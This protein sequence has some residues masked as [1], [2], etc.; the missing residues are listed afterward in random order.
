[1]DGEGGASSLEDRS[2]VPFEPESVMPA[3]W[4]G[5]GG[6]GGAFPLGATPEKRLIFAMLEDA[7]VGVSYGGWKRKKLRQAAKDRRWI[8]SDGDRPWSFVW[9]CHILG[10]DPSYIRRGLAARETPIRASHNIATS[11]R[12][13][14][15]VNGR[16]L[17]RAA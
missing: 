14:A 8:A 3:Q 13:V 10:L 12:W 17:G 5:P 16:Q 4:G 7:C 6:L 2:P 11:K 1:M 9:C 15:K